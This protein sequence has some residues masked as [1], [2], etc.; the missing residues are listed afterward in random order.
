MTS[1]NEDL[2]IGRLPETLPE[3]LHALLH[4]HECVCVP[5]L[6]G[7][8][9]REHPA[10]FN[11]FTGKLLPVH[12]TIFFNEALRNDDGLLGN[13][14]AER[15]KITY[16]EA[17]QLLRAAV[18]SLQETF[19]DHRQH[20]F[21]SLGI[22]F[23]NQEGRL[24]FIPSSSLNLHADAF[25][26]ME[27][28]LRQVV[29]AEKSQPAAVPPISAKKEEKTMPLEAEVVEARVV[30]AMAPAGVTRF[31]V[32]KV[33]AAVALMTLGG[34]LVIK[35]GNQFGQPAKQQQAEVLSVSTASNPKA[36]PALPEKPMPLAT[37]VQTEKAETNLSRFDGAY[38]INGGLFMSEQTAR[39]AVKAFAAAGYRP[40]IHKPENST[41]FRLI[42]TTAVD[43]SAALATIEVLRTQVQTHYSIEPSLLLSAHPAY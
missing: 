5:G 41:L 21:G 20:P 2:S 33:A 14:L 17:S 25:G 10:S 32:W 28:Q 43:E 37:D 22:F 16:N 1:M 7:F 35:L 31:K 23:C 11:R 18:S 4:D 34:A 8:L 42:V 24:F 19:R 9:R 39:F 3:L 27:V 36:V 40:K 26:L 29:A 13:L 30:E 38:Q 12:T 15:L 6:G